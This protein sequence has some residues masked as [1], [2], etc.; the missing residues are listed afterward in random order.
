MT[1]ITPGRPMSSKPPGGPTCNEIPAPRAR[2][3]RGAVHEE[4][5]S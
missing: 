5:T 1:R 2:P 4:G 3:R